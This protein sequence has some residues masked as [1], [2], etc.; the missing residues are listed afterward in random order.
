MLKQLLFS[1]LAMTLWLAPHHA[2]ADKFASWLDGVRAEAKTKGISDAT[3]KAALSGITE[4]PKVVKLDRKQP[5]GTKTFEQ[6]LKLVI[7]KTRKDR[8]VALYKKHQV[9]LEEV[10]RSY[11][12][13][14]E[15]IVALWAIE[16]NFGERMGDF[17]IIRSLATLAYDGRRSEFF[18][19]ELLKAMTIIDQGHISASDMIGSWAGAMGQ[20]QFMPSSFLSYAKDGNGDGKK[21][22]WGSKADVFA[23]IANYLSSV[24]W[25]ASIGWGA[26]ASGASESEITSYK[27]KS[28]LGS[29][30]QKGITPASAIYWDAP[31]ALLSGN[32]HNGGPY[33]LVSKNYDNILKWNRS[34]YFGIAVGTLADHIR[35]KVK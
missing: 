14:A 12:V 4:N 29:W 34:R 8:A 7:N 16:S 20:S 9:M 30:N 28:P 33:Y 1:L 22:I 3:I 2:H 11:G 32:H 31:V 13:Q 10:S 5:E 18:R 24:G 15:Y 23:S 26:P 27:D 6:Y 19:S 35:K 25:D 21:D 17:S